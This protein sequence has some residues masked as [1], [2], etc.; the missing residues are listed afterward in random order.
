MFQ[1]LK[2]FMAEVLVVHPPLETEISMAAWENEGAQTKKR[3]EISFVLPPRFCFY[4]LF[5][6]INPLGY[7]IKASFAIVNGCH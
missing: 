2:Q 3:A 1:A 4:P 7:G 6:R 5:L